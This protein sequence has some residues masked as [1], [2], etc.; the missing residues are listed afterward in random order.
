MSSIST[1]N[2]WLW[3]FMIAMI[4][5]VAI[6]SIGYKYYIVFACTCACVP[7][8][9]LPFFPETRNRNLELIDAV[10]R[11]AKSIWDIVPMARRLPRGDARVEV[12][13]VKRKDGEVSEQREYAWLLRHH[14]KHW[15]LHRS[16]LC[17]A[18][19]LVNLVHGIE[20]ACL[21]SRPL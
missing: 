1:A 10:F 2:H 18:L 21:L 8:V 14:F 11:E 3:N 13:E 19:C 7:L 17:Y 20:T 4:S 12:V 5:P 15:K 6:E 9:V 16:A